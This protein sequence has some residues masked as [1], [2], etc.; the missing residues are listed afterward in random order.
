[1]KPPLFD[2]L[3]DDTRARQVGL[4]GERQIIGRVEVIDW[5][6]ALSHVDARLY[7]SLNVTVGLINCLRHAHTG[8]EVTRDCS[9]QALP[10]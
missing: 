2:C 8:C 6:I 1:M 7:A 4:L 9:Y 10:F 3:V 5:A